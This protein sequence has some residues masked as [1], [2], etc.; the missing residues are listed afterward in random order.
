MEDIM[1]E[2]KKHFSKLGLLLLLSS[3]IIFVVQFAASKLFNLIPAVKESGNLSFL[4]VMLPMYVIAFPIIFKIF[5]SV[6]EQISTEKKKMNSGQIFLAFTICYAATYICN[7]IGVM[8]TAVI[9][10][11]KQGVVDNVMLEIT[12]SIHPAVN[13][14]VVVLCAPI[15]EE[16]LFRKTLM[17][18]TVQYGEGISILLSG[19]TFGLFHGNLNQFVYAFTL[20]VFFGFVYIKTRNVLYTIIL[21]M[22][23]NFMGSF[24]GA[25]ILDTSNYIEFANKLTEVMQTGGSEADLMAIITRYSNGL[26]IFFIYFLLIIAF[27]ITG[28]VLFFVNLRKYKLTP[29]TVTIGKGKRFSTVFLNVGMLLYTIFWTAQ[30]VLQLFA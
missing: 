30:I 22:C 21:H 11:L 15:M 5:Q 29:G 2:H 3:A 14:F 23:I 1:M 26:M 24:I 4:A 9:G 7:F 25:L 19:F 13:F 18:R 12:G 6:P 17:S 16:L 10:M 8:I 28:L 27:V 20:G